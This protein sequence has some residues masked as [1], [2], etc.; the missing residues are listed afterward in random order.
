MSLTKLATPHFPLAAGLRFRYQQE[1]PTMTRIVISLCVLLL[2]C[3]GRPAAADLAQPGAFAAGFRTVTVTRANGSTFTARLFYPATSPGENAPVD[4]S[5][6]PYPGVS[7]GHGF[8]QP[9]GNYQST[10]L[11][12]ATH[13]Y[14]VIATNSEGGLFPSHANFAADILRCLTWLEEQHAQP[15]SLLEGLVRVGAFGLSGHSMGG[16]AAIL[17]ASDPRIRAIVPLAAANTN[18]SSIAASSNFFVPVRHIVGSQDTIVI[19]ATTVQMFNNS[20]RAKQFVNLQGGFHC[21]F[22]EAQGFGCDSGSMSRS[23]QLAYVRR[24]M[25]EF[26]DL[27]LKGDESV[28]Q[29]VWDAEADPRVGLTSSPDSRIDPSA[30]TLTLRTG[31]RRLLNAT[32][33]NLGPDLGLFAIETDGTPWTVDSQPGL[34]GPV[35]PGASETAVLSL[36][37]PAGAEPGAVILR[38]AA[39]SLR[40]GGTRSV[41]QIEIN[42]ECGGDFDR[43]GSVDFFDIQ[44]F[45][46]AFLS[47]Q[48]DADYTGNGSFDFFDL[49]A[50]L[51]VFAAGCD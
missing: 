13:G 50:F 14:L 23:D 25:T 3:L 26:F 38:L 49:Q 32:V 19:P 5:G 46:Q 41:A 11:H 18:P 39:R 17:A 33:T 30:Q 47:A 2:A 21:G 20:A 28:W 10:L 24:Q 15:G 36:A 9:V 12:L 8:V 22:V 40:D 1:M 7:F 44:T 51:A 4:P 16:G 29:A 37:P 27:Y 43:N 45:L 48:P 6:G 35:D 31:A 42:L 34:V